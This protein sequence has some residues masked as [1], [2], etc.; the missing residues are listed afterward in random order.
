[1]KNFKQFDDKQKWLDELKK[2]LDLTLDDDLKEPEP[3]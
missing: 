2:S 3:D 1:M